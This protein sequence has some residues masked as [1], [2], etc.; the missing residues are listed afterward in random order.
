MSE[1]IFNISDLF[2]RNLTN[3]KTRRTIIYIIRYTIC[4]K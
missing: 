1:Q 3:W 2:I 4:G